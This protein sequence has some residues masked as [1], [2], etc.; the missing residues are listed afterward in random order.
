MKNGIPCILGSRQSSTWALLQGLLNS[1]KAAI[2]M[3][4]AQD[5]V[6][7]PT[8]SGLAMTVKVNTASQKA[9]QKMERKAARKN[10]G[11]GE[12][13]RLADI[14]YARTVGWAALQVLV[15]TP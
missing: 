3:V 10:K 1:F 5:E 12:S 11:K 8:D 15:A 2:H 14:E 6:N 13:T 9:I 7:N 4:K